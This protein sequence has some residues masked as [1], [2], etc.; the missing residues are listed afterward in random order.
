[1]STDS[2]SVVKTA[3]ERINDIAT[4]PEIA[5]AVM[6][7][8]ENPDTSADDVEQLV[9]SDAVLAARVLKVVNSSFYG[10][11]GEVGSIHQ[12]VVMLGLNAVKNIAIAASLGKLF[13]GT[14]IHESFDA[15]ELWQHSTAVACASRMLAKQ[16]GVDPE[17]AFLAG[18]LHKVGLVVEMQFAP[19]KLGQVIDRLLQPDAGRLL[20]IEAE[21]IGATHEQFGRAFCENWQFPVVLQEAVGAHHDPSVLDG[22]ARTLAA[23]ICVS[24]YL[25]DAAGVGYIGTVNGVMPPSALLEELGVTDD[26]IQA[27]L[28]ELPAAIKLAGHLVS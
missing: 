5:R 4:L 23:I 1:M 7:A 9:S 20:D 27:V 10:M 11:P 28:A 15:R 14:S 21:V 24:N 16:L 8:A 26:D 25:S 12:A 17:Q 3:L 13:R 22:E 18:M 2:N 19:E 6:A